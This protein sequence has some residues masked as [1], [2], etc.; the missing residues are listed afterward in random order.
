VGSP[1]INGFFR[2]NTWASNTLLL[3]LVAGV[4]VVGVVQE[5]LKY[6]AGATSVFQ[7]R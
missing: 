2:V 6:A 3:R 1:L 7:Q 5:F 4:L